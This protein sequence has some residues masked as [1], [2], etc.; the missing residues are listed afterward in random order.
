MIL[1]SESDVQNSNSRRAVCRDKQACLHV[2]WLVSAEIVL[3]FDSQF[4]SIDS[5]RERHEGERYRLEPL[6]LV[7]PTHLVPLTNTRGLMG[8][9]PEHPSHTSKCGDMN[10]I[11]ENTNFV[12]VV[13]LVIL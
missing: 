2:I 1:L 5:L 4:A 11:T 12:G 7:V 8:S 13:T 6:G 9:S 3:W 10:F